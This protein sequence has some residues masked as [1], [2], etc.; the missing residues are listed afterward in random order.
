MKN[1]SIRN[2]FYIS[3]MLVVSVGFLGLLVILF[4]GDRSARSMESQIDAAER[5]QKTNEL[6]A[7][8]AFLQLKGAEMAN[9]LSEASYISFQTAEDKFEEKARDLHSDTTLS[10]LL[11]IKLEI[12]EALLDAMDDFIDDARPEAE[13]HL[14]V[15]RA[16]SEKLQKIIEQDVQT[17]AHTLR[18]ENMRISKWRKISTSVTISSVLVIILCLL[19]LGIFLSRH[20]ISPLNTMIPAISH[21]AHS[22]TTAAKN[23]IPVSTNN[24]IGKT[25]SALNNLFVEVSHAIENSK[26]EAR[27]AE[28]NR[29]A[30]VQAEEASQAKSL[31]LANMSHEIRTPMN[32]II[33]MT[34]ILLGSTLSEDQVS[35]VE[36]I[37]NSCDALLTIINDV[38]DFSKVEAGQL[39]LKYE[40][41]NL[42][43]LCEE[44]LAL[45]GPKARQ[46]S[47]DLTLHYP[48]DTHKY[49]DGDSG[50]IRQILMNV[51]GNAIKFTPQGNVSISVYAQ[52]MHTS[53]QLTLAIEDSGIGIPE[54]KLDSIFKAFEQVD[55]TSRRKFEGTGLG[56]AISKRLIDLMD[57]TIDVVSSSSGSIFTINLVL[58]DAKVKDVEKNNHECVVDFSDCS[59]LVVDDIELNRRTIKYRLENWG[60][61]VSTACDAATARDWLRE[62]AT[63]NDLPDLAIIDQQ[64]PFLSGLELIEEL[65]TQPEFNDIKIVLYSSVDNLMEEKTIESGADLLLLKPARTK[66]M[67]AALT[68]VLNRETEKKKTSTENSRFFENGM[69]EIFLDM[70][71]LVAEDSKTNQKVIQRY[72][73]EIPVTIQIA[74][75]GLECVRL[76]DQYKPDIILMDWSM[77]EMNGIDATREIRN[78][79]KLKDLSPTKIIGLSANALDTHADL[80]VKSGMDGYLTKPIRRRALL[81]AL[82]V[83]ALELID[84]R[85]INSAAQ[86]MEQST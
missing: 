53:H 17:A 37:S 62:K 40:P 31:F 7:A 49:F 71:I 61:C 57:G 51:V 22:P 33:G 65:R 59:V 3:L 8:S 29:Q 72:L 63:R 12:S 42:E 30:K 83:H 14:L 5:L 76:F 82:A 47:I 54:N 4:T 52:K 68:K 18:Q 21:A 58:Q 16:E 41:F 66:Q 80:A 34:D 74:E 56:L 19:G 73:D 11:S 55:G 39:S 20:I 69:T 38:L 81:D 1:I 46:K 77:P 45:L 86:E 9:S 79:E 25:V 48:V 13:Q 2:I 35:H 24:E 67:R 78:R 10:K 75:N 85:A 23:V 60:F 28:V 64:M 50:R 84:N 36:T 43:E 26:V 32:G 15:A 70:T 44:L 6:A 27:R